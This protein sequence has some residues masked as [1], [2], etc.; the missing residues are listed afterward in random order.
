LPRCPA[1][2]PSPPGL[3]SRGL[4]PLRWAGPAR[5]AGHRGRPA[6]HARQRAHTPTEVCDQGLADKLGIPGAYLR[7]LCAEHPAL[8][9]ANDNGW[10]ERSGKRYLI[11]ALR[12]DSGGAVARAFLSDGYKI[13]D[14][15]D[16]LMAALTASA[17]PARR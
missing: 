3:P 13:I 5:A 12:G 15:L 4:V 7:R 11:R 14:N 1:A 10:L 17:R 2:P 6:A 9:D 8:Y 16:V